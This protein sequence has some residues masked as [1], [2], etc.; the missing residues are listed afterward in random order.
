[1]LSVSIRR[2]AIFINMFAS[3]GKYL[4]MDTVLVGREK[5]SVADWLQQLC[6]VWELC[7]DFFQKPDGL[8]SHER[9]S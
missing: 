1:M 6:C 4:R 5:P 9:T 3:Y 8:K 7:V 2:A